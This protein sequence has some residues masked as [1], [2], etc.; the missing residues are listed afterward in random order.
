[1]IHGS[2]RIFLFHFR[3]GAGHVMKAGTAV[4]NMCLEPQFAF[5]HEGYGQP[6]MKIFSGINFQF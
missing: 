2:F 1:M 3:H 6:A 4:V 5:L